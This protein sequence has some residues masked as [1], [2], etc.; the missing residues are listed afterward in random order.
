MD[1]KK[2]L[3]LALL[4]ASSLPLIIFTGISLNNSMQTAKGNG[5][6]REFK[7]NRNCSGKDK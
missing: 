7:A 5:F 1:I 4:V 6:V 3:T 2:K